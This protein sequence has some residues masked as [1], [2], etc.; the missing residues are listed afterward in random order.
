M[1]ILLATLFLLPAQRAIL[2]REWLNEGKFCRLKPVEGSQ[3]REQNEGQ[4]RQRKR[5]TM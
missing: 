1:A 2:G 3:G 4:T 5:R